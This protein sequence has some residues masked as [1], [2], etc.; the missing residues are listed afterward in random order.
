MSGSIRSLSDNQQYRV[1]GI[2]YCD[3]I[4]TT[5][6]IA[7]A[8]RHAQVGCKES[9]SHFWQAVTFEMANL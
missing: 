6:G 1:L 8:V 7:L 4:G 5:V 2:A 3:Y 9:K